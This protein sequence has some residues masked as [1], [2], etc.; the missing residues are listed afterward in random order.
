MIQPA[1]HVKDLTKIYDE[2]PAVNAISFDVAPGETVSLLGG[3]G[4]GKTTTISMLMGILTPTSGTVHVLGHDMVKNRYP[5]LSR[6]NFSSPYVELPYRL[7]VFEN[8]HVAALL[9]NIEHPK[10]RVNELLED[11]DLAEFRKRPSGE[12]SEGQKTRLALAKSLINKPSLLLLDEPTASI[13]PDTGDR[14]RSYLEDYRTRENAAILLA[15]HNMWEVERLA[16]RVLMMRKGVIV[17][18]GTPAELL[19][20]YGRD[21]LEEVFLHLARHHDETQDNIEV[22]H[23][24]K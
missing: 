8:L 7:N 13:D 14:L 19:N 2:Y 21:N 24:T 23:E 17:D 22:A 3:N 9:Y 20:K 12:L 6:M 4:A 16:H 11:L 18:Q 5:A 1:I 15:S 10:D